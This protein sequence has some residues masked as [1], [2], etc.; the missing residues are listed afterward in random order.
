MAVNIDFLTD[1]YF[2]FDSPV[3]YELKTGKKL[4]IKPFYME[5]RLIYLQGSHLLQKDKRDKKLN[6]K[7]ELDF[8][9][10]DVL[11]DD[12]AN[13]VSTGMFL[14]EA[15]GYSMPSIIFSNGKYYVANYYKPKDD[16]GNELKPVLD[17]ES[18]IDTEEW[19]ELKRIIL[20]QNDS[21]YDDTFYYD[22]TVRRNLEIE[23]RLK[24]KGTTP[25][26]LERQFY[27]IMAHTGIPKEEQMKLTL[28]GFKLLFQEVIGEA[29]FFASYALRAKY[30]EKGQTAD[31]WIWQNKKSGMDKIGV[32]ASSF[33]QS[34]G[35]NDEEVF[36]DAD[37]APPAQDVDIE[38]IRRRIAN[39]TY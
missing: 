29:E 13:W 37:D 4:F 38:E 32:K 18:I 15:I 21:D 26:N 1:A 39:G 31:H 17:K 23:N 28:R 25:P 9:V 2:A 22:E 5:K 24:S 11:G 36:A 19:E 8:Y 12:Y 14:N 33:I 35:F 3:P 30:S 10:E 6:D 34:L 20:Y 27:I 16:D 7:P